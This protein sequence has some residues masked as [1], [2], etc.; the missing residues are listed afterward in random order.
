MTERQKE[1]LEGIIAQISC[2][3]KQGAL[4]SGMVVVYATADDREALRALLSA[5][6]AGEG[7]AVKSKGRGKKTLPAEECRSIADA[8][9]RLCPS[10]PS[11]KLLT[12]ARRQAIASAKDKLGDKTF[13]DLFRLVEASDFLSG[14]SRKWKAS[15]DW[16]LKPSNL[17]K[18]LEGNYTEQTT[19][20]LADGSFDVDE[21]FAAAMKKSYG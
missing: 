2:Q 7:Q 21:F 10:L 15:F 6:E 14:R 18:I 16:I 8:Y 12:D 13:E 11:V 19:K 5:A 4:P 17:V 1:V 3:L 9:N 20:E